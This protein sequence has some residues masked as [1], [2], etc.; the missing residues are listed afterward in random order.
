MGRDGGGTRGG[1]QA[2]SPGSFLSAVESFLAAR[3]PAKGSPHTLSAYRA[4][5][6]GVGT[7]VAAAVGVTLESLELGALHKASLRS[8]F[9][10][11]AADHARA[12]L[13]R[14]WSAWNV[15]FDHLVAEDMVEANPMA[16][17]AK[18]ANVA[19]PAK[20]IR[21]LDVAGRLLAVAAVTDPSARHPWPARDV[22]L[23]ATFSVTGARLA[24][25]LSLS[26]TSFDGPEG[27]RRL[28]IV[29]KGGKART[30]PVFAAYEGLVRAYLHERATRFPR[31]RLELATTPLFVTTTGEAMAPHQVPYLVDRL[32]RRAG[33]RAQVPK[34][35]LVHALRHT[36]ATTALDG[37]ASVLEV[38]QLLGHASLDTTRRYVEATANEL[39]DA[40][41]AHPAR[42]AVERFA[43]DSAGVAP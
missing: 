10:D 15:F 26:P 5:L 43:G 14:A 11:L 29:G 8:A 39:R 13:R 7:R 12:S 2:H 24:E 38:S 19:G 34:G 18:P 35:A 16:G 25:A 17:V 32:Y 36:F 20:V 33:M 4:D 40:V 27:E 42:L 30:V 41:R 6:V 1:D 9:A 28:S 22:A 37:G 21:G 23:L 3:A 31:H